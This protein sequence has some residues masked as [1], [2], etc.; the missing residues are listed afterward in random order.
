[1]RF[2][3]MGF[4][5]DGCKKWMNWIVLAGAGDPVGYVHASRAVGGASAGIAWV[6]GVPWQG[7]G[8]ATAAVAM[9]VDELVLRGVDE[10]VADIHPANK[11]SEGV[12]RRIGMQATDQDVDGETRWAGQAR[13]LSVSDA[14]STAGPAAT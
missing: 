5:P 7:C 10:I 1:M 13:R 6:I 2:S 9:M 12:A 4:S 11:P 3:A 14:D 8:F